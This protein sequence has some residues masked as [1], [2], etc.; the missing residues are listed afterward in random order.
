VPLPSTI[1]VPAPAPLIVTS[2]TMS[3]SPVA[4]QASSGPPIE[5]V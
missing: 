1:V 2:P 5:S 4:A 3:R